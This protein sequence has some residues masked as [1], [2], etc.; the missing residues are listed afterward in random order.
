MGET[1]FL[2]VN[3][4]MENLKHIKSFSL[5]E[6]MFDNGKSFWGDAGAGILPLCMEKIGDRLVPK[7]LVAKRG[8]EANEPGTWGVWGGK[9]DKEDKNNPAKAALREFREET[10]YDGKMVL[11]PSYV[12]KADGF[13][14]H[15]FIGVVPKKFDPVLNWETADYEWLTLGEVSKLELHFGLKAL[16]EHGWEDI[17]KV[18]DELAA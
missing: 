11:H 1:K 4:T 16:L 12:F 7:F 8:P 5:F 3:S 6:E 15:N 10:E 17:K 2:G 9:I 14:Y 18:T 13:V